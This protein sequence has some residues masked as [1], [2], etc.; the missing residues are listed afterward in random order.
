MVD[1]ARTEAEGFWI[2]ATIEFTS[3][4]LD[5]VQAPVLSF[6]ASTDTF[7]FPYALP[8]TPGTSHTYNIIR[9]GSSVADTRAFGGVVATPT[10]GGVPEVDITHL[11]GSPVCD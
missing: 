9:S 6:T 1:A 5:G 4:T 11:L 2:G 8:A 10:V 3:G 7:T